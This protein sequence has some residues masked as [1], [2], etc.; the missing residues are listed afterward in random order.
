VQ[1]SAGKAAADARLLVGESGLRQ[2][3]N[4][5]RDCK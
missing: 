1:Q 3:G 5:E 2:R 4:G